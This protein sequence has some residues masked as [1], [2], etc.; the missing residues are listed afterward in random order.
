[1]RVQK[2]LRQVRVTG[3]DCQKHGHARADAQAHPDAT[4]VRAAARALPFAGP[5]T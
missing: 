4:W 1:M 2:S 3:I 5:S